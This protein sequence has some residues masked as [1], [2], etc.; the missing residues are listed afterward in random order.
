MAQ[1]FRR[2]SGRLLSLA[3]TLVFSLSMVLGSLVLSFVQSVAQAQASPTGV[4]ATL[5]GDLQTALGAANAWT[6]SDPATR[7]HDP[8]GIGVYIFTGFL[9]AGT[10][11]YKVALNGSWDVS[12]PGGNVSL[13]VPDGG[14]TVTIR[15]NAATHAVSD[16]INNP[17]RQVNLAGDFNGW[18]NAD[19]AYQL[20]D[21]L[22]VGAYE[23]TV[24]L[25]AGHHEYKITLDGQWTES[26]PAWNV[27]MD[28]GRDRDVTFYYYEGSH[29][30]K[31]AV[32]SGDA[33][34]A[35]LAS[36]V[37]P[38][39]GAS[40]EWNPSDLTTRLWDTDDSGNYHYQ[41]FLP[42][43]QWEYK[44]ALNR[45]WDEAYP[46][47]NVRLNVTA[48]RTLVVFTFNAATKKVTDSINNALRPGHDN[49]I[50]WNGLYHDSRDALYRSPFGAVTAGTPVTLRMQAAAGD[51]ISASVRLWDDAQRQ[52]RLV[53]M[54]VVGRSADG[55]HEYWSA[56]LTTLGHPGLFYYHFILRDGSRSTYYYAASGHGG[57]GAPSD[58]ALGND[59]QITVYDPAFR[60]PEWLQNAVIY[61]IFPD[62]FSNGDKTNDP[63]PT[64]PDVYG[65]PIVLHQDW[66]ALPSQPPRGADFFGGDLKGVLDKLDYLMS[67]H[68]DVIYFNP[69][70]RAP[71]NHKYDTTDYMS[72]DPHFGDQKLFEKLV[73][74]AGKRGMRVVL[75]GV[76]NHTGS[77]SVY[78]DKY[79]R[80]PTLG[81][82]ESQ[83]SPY[84]GWYD[85]SQWPNRY[86]AWWGFDS[87]PK[88][89]HMRNGAFNESLENYIYEGKDSVAGHWLKDGASGWRLDVPNEVANPVWPLFRQAVKKTRPDAA[90]IGEIWD[91]ASQY[92]LGNEFDS[93][94]NYRFRDAV[95][96]F[97]GNGS[98]DARGLDEAL[99]SIRE[100]YPAPAFVAMMNLVDSHD[101]A[102]IRNV[103]GES[104]D[105]QKLVALFQLTYAG[106]PS[107]YYG[108]EAGV[109]GGPDPD[110]RRTYPWGQEDQNLVMY[111]QSLTQLRH[112]NSALREGS[113]QTLLADAEQGLYGFGRKTEE[114][115]AVVLVN[116]QSTAAAAAVNLAGFVPEGTVLHD[117]L[118]RTKT[119][120]VSGGQITV[121]LGAYQGLVLLTDDDLDLVPPAAPRTLIA[122]PGNAQVAL[123]WQAPGKGVPHAWEEEDGS[124]AKPGRTPS[125]PD[126]AEGAPGR[127][128]AGYNV[129][130]TTVPG[131]QYV[132]MNTALVPTTAYVD[133]SATNATVYYYAVAA[134]DKAG[135]E[136]PRSADVRAVPSVPIGWVGNLAPLDVTHT[137]SAVTPTPVVAAEVWADGLTNQP[138]QGEG[139]LA[140]LGYG[141]AGSDPS[142]IG[143]GGWAWTAMDYAGDAGDAGNN[144]RYAAGLLPDQAGA[145]GLAARFSSDAGTT[146]HYTNA[147]T[148]TVAPATD[149]E[150]PAAPT[151]LTA[152][153]SLGQITLSW[154]RGIEPDLYGYGVYRS[155]TPFNGALPDAS[156]RVARMAAD[157]TAYTDPGLDPE[158]TY[159]YVV[160]ALDTAFNRSTPSAQVSA[161]ARPTQVAVTFNVIVPDYTPAGDTVFI[162]GDFPGTN[163]NPGGLALTKVD[164]THWTTT[165]IL[166]EGTVLNYKYARGSWD[167]VEKDTFGQEIA[168][169]Q[170]VAA[171]S[172]GNTQIQLD[173]VARWRDLTTVVTEPADGFTTT[174]PTVTVRGNAVPGQTVTVNGQ[175]VTLDANGYFSAVADLTIGA[176][177]ITVV[178]P[179]KD[180]N[181]TVTITRTVTRTQ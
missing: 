37:Q 138:D 48:D 129:Y 136:G 81:A 172:S 95:W 127:I 109:S 23:I 58:S 25:P 33:A 142:S 40:S 12:Y 45:T 5:V 119:Y 15:Y 71:S 39:L 99:T 62:R 66:N 116:R 122:A 86:N 154:N 114:Q 159:Y 4:Y 110:S 162:A 163:W 128:I 76:F 90:I 165:M 55:K 140:E 26:Y 170:L 7:M 41:A 56:T 133:T 24:K 52:A 97:F 105:K 31:D 3:T 36:N 8:A 177:T 167:Q 87:L 77:D 27:S 84:F 82:F 54:Q 181:G 42:K 158:I 18:N 146:W 49:D 174:S 30:V 14:R 2:R 124:V 69:I 51:L 64:E 75:D 171:G 65:S 150:A 102:R 131:G 111:Y 104:V 155:T 168:N 135:N 130:R 103:L 94:M 16:T 67:L 13:T 83:D 157:T 43:G 6:P 22:G 17:G 117:G 60:T 147:G 160:V 72:V 132:K 100:D 151:G 180:F 92:L 137:L 107:I 35:V 98:M 29:R 47:S 70:F 141:P 101:T 166:D 148:L 74:E 106:A 68:V 46:G 79:S 9:P 91:N 53:P 113:V 50:W 44:I 61:Q 63:Q 59:Y 38:L 144:D 10:Y 153:G 161:Q 32:T 139:M 125:L 123:T 149:T 169:R 152:R 126:Q 96:N 145:F 19:P 176:N 118:D 173:T 108:D 175:P 120:T 1:R 156:L 28:L 20:T 73:K 11:E 115:A 85:F 78:F 143:S 134:V 89:I 93:V 179:A 178:G 121:G 112:H 80:Y 34:L 21:P 164:A 88:L 57:P